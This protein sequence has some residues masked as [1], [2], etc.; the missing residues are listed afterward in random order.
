MIAHVKTFAKFIHRLRPFPL[1]N[2][3]ARIKLQAIGNG[4]EI[5]RAVTPQ[6]RNR[7]LDAADALPL[8]G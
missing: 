6:E 4:L 5:E 3:M 7:I 1:G 8:T 2:P